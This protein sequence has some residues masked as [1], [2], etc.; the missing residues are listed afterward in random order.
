[1]GKKFQG[2][3]ELGWERNFMGS[4]NLDGKEISGDP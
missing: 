4:V 3:R 1:M 2:I